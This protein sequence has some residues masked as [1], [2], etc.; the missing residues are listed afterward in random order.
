MSY[1]TKIKDG[2]FVF[3]LEDVLNASTRQEAFFHWLY[4]DAEF[5]RDAKIAIGIMGFLSDTKTLDEAQQI[6][7]RAYRKSFNKKGSK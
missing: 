1:P 2:K 6:E 4:G 7:I 5:T 3:D